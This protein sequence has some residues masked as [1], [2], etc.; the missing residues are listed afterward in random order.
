VRVQEELGG[1]LHVG[2]SVASGK[3]RVRRVALVRIRRFA[4]FARTAQF[5]GYD[6]SRLMR[7]IDLTKHYRE[8]LHIALRV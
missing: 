5:P 3:R 2:H 1:T 7:W 8:L 6:P 4:E